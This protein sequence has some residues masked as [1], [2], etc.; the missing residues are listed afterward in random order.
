VRH[1]VISVLL[2]GVSL[3][4]S[5][6]PL[7]AHHGSAVYDM[8]NMTTVKGTVTEFQFSNPHAQILFDVKDEKGNVEKWVGETNSATAL[9]RLGWKK[10]TLKSGDQVTVVG[11]RSKNGSATMHLHKLMLAGQE[12]PMER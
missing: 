2:L 12:L 8:E 11:W 6:E 4:T 3:L 9:Y 7:S 1:A 10:D 5:L